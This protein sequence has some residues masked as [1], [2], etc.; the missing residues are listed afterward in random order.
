MPRMELPSR[1]DVDLALKEL[2]IED[3]R[4]REAIRLFWERQRQKKPREVTGRSI[5]GWAAFFIV[6]AGL[7]LWGMMR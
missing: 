5:L 3:A 2:E 7:I 4:E 6:L 1:H